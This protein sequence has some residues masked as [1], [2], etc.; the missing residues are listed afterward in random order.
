MAGEGQPFTEEYVRRYDGGNFCVYG[1]YPQGFVTTAGINGTF[2]GDRY[3]QYHFTGTHGTI[4]LPRSSASPEESQIDANGGLR[5][6][7]DTL[8]NRFR[9]EV[10]KVSAAD[11]GSTIYSYPF[12]GYDDSLAP[13]HRNEPNLI[14]KCIF[15][16]Y[17]YRPYDAR[18]RDTFEIF[19]NATVRHGSPASSTDMLCSIYNN[20]EG[21][22][23]KIESPNGNYAL[24]NNSGEYSLDVTDSDV[25]QFLTNGVFDVSLASG[26]SKCEY[27]DGTTVNTTNVCANGITFAKTNDYYYYKGHFG[28]ALYPSAGP[29]N[30]EELTTP[31][32]HFTKVKPS[33]ATVAYYPYLY[34]NCLDS[35]YSIS[36][37]GF[38][39]NDNIDHSSVPSDDP[40]ENPNG[41]DHDGISRAAFVHNLYS[42][43]FAWENSTHGIR[44]NIKFIGLRA[45][46][47]ESTG[48]YLKD[49]DETDMIFEKES[50]STKTYEEYVGSRTITENSEWPILD[51]NY[52]I[53]GNSIIF[54]RDVESLSTT[55]EDVPADAKNLTFIRSVD[56]YYYCK[57]NEYTGPRPTFN[58]K[59]YSF[60]EDHINM[61]NRETIRSSDNFKFDGSFGV[62]NDVVNLH[63]LS[64]IVI[65]EVTDSNYVDNDN[66]LSFSLRLASGTGSNKKLYSPICGSYVIGPNSTGRYRSC[67]A[68]YMDLK[69]EEYKQPIQIS[70]NII[71]IRKTID[72]DDTGKHD[73]VLKE[74][75]FDYDSDPKGENFQFLLDWRSMIGTYDNDEINAFFSDDSKISGSLF[76]LGKEGLYEDIETTVLY[77]N[78]SG[79]YKDRHGNPTDVPYCPSEDNNYYYVAD[80]VSLE[81]EI[82]GKLF[83]T[84]EES[85]IENN[86]QRISSN[87][88]VLWYM[89][90]D[91]SDGNVPSAVGLEIIDAKGI[92]YKEENNT[93]Y[94]SDIFDIPFID[95]TER[96]KQSSGVYKSIESDVGIVQTN[97]TL[98]L[99]SYY[100]FVTKKP[101]R[102]HMVF[103]LKTSDGSP[104][105]SQS[106]YRVH[107]CCRMMNGRSKFNDFVV[108]T[109]KL[110]PTSSL[111]YEDTNERTTISTDTIFFSNKMK[112]TEKSQFGK[113]Y[114][115]AGATD[116]SM[117]DGMAFTQ[118]TYKDAGE[119]KFN[120][121][122]ETNDTITSYVY[123]INS[124][125][126]GT[127][128]EYSSY[129]PPEQNQ[130][131]YVSCQ[132]QNNNIE[133]PGGKYIVKV[134]RETGC[135]IKCYPNDFKFDYGD[136]IA[137]DSIT[138]DE[139][140]G[141][142]EKVYS[143]GDQIIETHKTVVSKS[144]DVNIFDIEN[145]EG[146]GKYTIR[147]YTNKED[148]KQ[149]KVRAGTKSAVK[150]NIYENGNFVD[151][152]V[153]GNRILTRQ[154]DS[155]DEIKEEKYI[156]LFLSID[157][158]ET[159]YSDTPELYDLYTAYDESTSMLFYDSTYYENIGGL[160]LVFDD[161]RAI[162]VD[163]DI[164]IGPGENIV[165][166][167]TTEDYLSRFH[168][169]DKFLY[170]WVKANIS[171][172]ENSSTHIKSS[173][174][175][176][177]I[178]ATRRGRK[179]WNSDFGYV[180]SENGA[181]NNIKLIVG[182]KD[183]EIGKIKQGIVDDPYNMTMEY[184]LMYTYEISIDGV[185]RKTVTYD[186]K[187]KS[188]LEYDFMGRV[189]KYTNLNNVIKRE[190]Y[191]YY[192]ETDDDVTGHKKGSY[193]YTNDTWVQVPVAVFSPIKTVSPIVITLRKTTVGYGEPI[194]FVNNTTDLKKI[195]KNP[196]ITMSNG[197][198]FDWDDMDSNELKKEQTFDLGEYTFNV[199][200]DLKD[201]LQKNIE[202]VKTIESVEAPKLYVIERSVY[203]EKVTR[204]LDGYDLVYPRRREDVLFA[205]NEWITAENINRR[206]KFMMEN[207]DYLVSQTK[208]YLKPPSKFCGFYGDFQ[209]VI[210]GEYRRAF[211]YV[212]NNDV[213]IYRL[214][215]EHTSI[216]DD[217]TTIKKCNA[218]CVDSEP[219]L[220]SHQNGKI[221]IY[222]TSKY[223]SYRSSIIP[224]MV[225][226][227]ITYIDRMHYSKETEKLYLLSSNTHKL[228]IFN[229]YSENLRNT[230]INCTYFGE[231]GGYGGPGVH[232]K[233]NTPNDFFVSMH[234]DKDDKKTDEI[235]ICD[236][237]N[238]VIKHFSIKGQWIS[239]ID[240]RELGYDLI[241]V[242]C[243]YKKD[244]HI[245]TDRYVVTFTYDGDVKNGF[246]LNGGL[247]KP[248]MI[249][250]Q[251][252][253]GFLYVLY[254]HWIDKYNLE[255]KYVGRFAEADDFTYTTMCVTDNH[256]IYI[257]T[258]KNILHYND[259]LR[260]RTIAAVE[261][262]VNQQ[263]SIDEIKINR[264]E[265][266]QDV[267]LNT[268]LQRM[269]DNITMYALCIF[270]NI[271]KLN[272]LDEDKRIV[273][274]DYVTYQ[275]IYDF[276]HKE[277]IFVGINEL[278]TVE[279][280]NRSL[281]QMYDLLQ[282]M[283][284]T[285]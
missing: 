214:Y 25:E 37:Y 259:S 23:I 100:N 98:G 34:V 271:V 14:E 153:D 256:D 274:L 266:I 151:V 112:E 150:K 218:L 133:G 104:C 65:E 251:Y 57:N 143:D 38:E 78:I 4:T 282:L 103:R 276:I 41:W 176:F 99:N 156:H 204:V 148:K 261:N 184:Y 62:S 109:V 139:G 121:I 83:K 189:E 226:E 173:K 76:Y 157:D 243:D 221:S 108:S 146:T 283:L 105:M 258:N 20:H 138:Y 277:R 193:L 219:N 122:K 93:K 63:S 127:L 43:R 87:L 224:A 13:Y 129:L 281:N 169:A 161:F 194:I 241:S 12:K 262:A 128:M 180:N 47:P 252:Q 8:R 117:G 202:N 141:T 110:N 58:P 118:K 67:S 113:I 97:D 239:T 191:L 90:L 134:L 69:N 106:G 61:C 203:D 10:I 244:V 9:E 19:V 270:G 279:T 1:C 137:Y 154:I 206:F 185:V 179:I 92:E 95:A 192:V 167:I 89:V 21:Y 124:H 114:T 268:S 130:L 250:P 234:I 174:M 51:T 145:R 49:D 220:Y 111:T 217:N 39:F 60:L 232:S 280:I 265:N 253:A 222:N 231:I 207:L 68:I 48:Y 85:S 40:I 119:S 91:K 195:Y 80:S 142:Y 242:C 32:E 28:V 64:E 199:S 285:I 165:D 175:L 120:V 84:I 223:E 44:E 269:Y 79:F 201:D 249:R 52:K 240:L 88:N 229:P 238:H 155:G 2:V 248:L 159:N 7:I 171:A 254:E 125:D 29:F 166:Y 246:V 94:V 190:G 211:G 212:P 186:G 215:N 236:A 182:E 31:G 284:D 183:N 181:L 152:E 59:S 178:K 50:A 75:V 26:F 46:S 33:T 144:S 227:Y 245:L 54:F 96:L 216:D 198:P 209:S 158:T 73:C 74:I 260:V 208:I 162:K 135:Y 66:K 5:L 170:L 15:G 3:W 72:V 188:T 55:G 24:K 235:W 177:N 160:D 126:I 228:Y 163:Y 213:E 275:K 42:Y 255:G 45:L 115:Y 16:K 6:Y 264:D 196:K 164:E 233:F 225:N 247:A 27:D 149:I 187:P 22:K 107:L 147:F 35:S 71:D 53:E 273:D 86:S 123:G 82:K 257:A 18:E 17:Y 210:N 136:L 116:F 272:S 132:W 30:A 77:N 263:W 56:A 70:D 101:D 168:L 267:V 230:N 81:C 102:V 200:A 197:T 172:S 140:K 237:G 131:Y 278:V 11:S 205:P 36:A